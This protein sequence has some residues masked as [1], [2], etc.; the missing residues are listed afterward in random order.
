VNVIADKATHQRETR[1]LIGIITLN[2]GGEDLLVPVFL[3]CP[4]CPKGDGEYLK[5]N[6][7]AVIDHFIK[8][9]Q[10]V[11][12]TGDG[13]Y[14]LCKV[15]EKLE[16]HYRTRIFKT[17]DEMHLA[18]TVDTKLRKLKKFAWAVKIT[19]V[20]GKGVKFVAW[21]REWWHF[22]SVGEELEKNEDFD[23]KMYRPA[24]FSETK[25]ANSAS[26]VYTKFREL[27]PALV[28]TLEEVKQ[29]VYNG[30]SAEKVKAEKADEVQSGIMNYLFCLSLSALVD[31][32]RVYG[33]I[34]NILQIINIL[35]HERYEMFINKLAK[36]RDMKNYVDL[37]DYPCLM[38]VE[39]DE[40]AE[41]IKE[42]LEKEEDV[43]EIL[44]E[45]C[46]WPA[47]HADTRDMLKKGK[48]RGVVL[49]QL[50]M[51]PT[52]TREGRQQATQW[53]EEDRQSTAIKVYRRAEELVSFLVEGLGEKV[54]NNEAIIMMNHSRRLLNIESELIK[55]KTNGAANVSNLGWRGFKSAALFFEPAV[56]TRIT[57][58][59][60]REQYRE[61]NRRL[62]EISMKKETMGL[63]SKKILSLFFDPKMKMYVDIEGVLSVLARACV[64][65]GVEA[66]V[67]SW[68]SVMENHCTSVR[69]INF[70]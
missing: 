41:D 4:K 58:E 9:E 33:S 43:K 32:Y 62:E 69:W 59:E 65:K 31:T 35:P 51:D 6:I 66:I 8:K 39:R 19:V 5:D 36:F 22:F 23:F 56:F 2:P 70:V 40:V 29:D 15:V 26:L 60:L 54:Y 20:I 55:V 50:T 46:C 24:A 30:N 12:F 67:E 57:E 21:G 3:G 34:S 1:Q 7:V 38:V 17:W 48:Y 11:G 45:I 49:G 13:V 25:F 47:L 10:L 53:L 68:V 63:S 44:E 16:K 37:E 52:N 42:I 18:A 64:S 61:F 14:I 27:F 28:I